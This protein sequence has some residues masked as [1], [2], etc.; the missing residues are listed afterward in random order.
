[1]NHRMESAAQKGNAFCEVEIDPEKI[2]LN[3]GDAIVMPSLESTYRTAQARKILRVVPKTD[4][5]QS[6]S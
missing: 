6:A 5:A 4:T 1:M 2:I 3:I